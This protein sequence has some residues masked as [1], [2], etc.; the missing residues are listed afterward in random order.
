MVACRIGDNPANLGNIGINSDGDLDVNSSGTVYY[1]SWQTGSTSE[2]NTINFGPPPSLSSTNEITTSS[3][4]SGIAFD[5]A[6]TLWMGTYW[7]Q[8]LYTYDFGPTHSAS[9]IYDLSADLGGNITGLSAVV[10]EPASMAL[11]G[12]GLVGLAATRIR[13]RRVV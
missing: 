8:N 2:M 10:P 12:M 7:D 4:W 3:G 5:A 6:D 13:K 11:M 9:L 1:T